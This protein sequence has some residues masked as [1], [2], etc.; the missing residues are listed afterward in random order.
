MSAI[1][2]SDVPWEA[3]E[4][5]LGNANKRFSG[6]TS[7]M[8]QVARIQQPRIGLVVLGDHHLPDKFPSVGFWQLARLCRQVPAKGRYRVFHA[9]RN[10]EMIQALLLKVVFR[11]RIRIVFTS[12]AQ[13]RK[14]WLTRWLMQRMDGLLSTCT[15][16]AGYMEIQPDRIIPHG[17]DTR[18]YQPEPNKAALA[19]QLSM[20]T[21]HCIGIFGRVRAQKGV[22][23]LIDAALELLPRYPTFSV[24]VVGEI[25]ADQRDFVR[26]LEQRIADA[27]LTDRIRFTGELPFEQVPDWFRA[28]SIIT[29]LSRN[30]GFGL[31]V[32]EAMSCAVPVVA[33]K[34]GAWPDIIEPGRD[35]ELIDAGDLDALIE[36]L[37]RLMSD[38][39]YRE[40]L[41]DAGRVKIERHY[42]VEHEAQALIDYYRTVASR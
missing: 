4:L 25:T 33:T 10:L 26:R 39:A 21:D 6:V 18:Q 20:P 29:A 41:G 3:V 9:R 11:A 32:L 16:A 28:M 42:R 8:L 31:T 14:T 2:P 15:A 40:R 23:L 30:E 27:E 37:D 35:G 7:T 12:T 24:A 5:I 36:R 38:P 22:D 13:R 17:I 34:A 1:Q 19:S